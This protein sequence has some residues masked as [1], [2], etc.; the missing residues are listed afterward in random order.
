[1]FESELSELRSRLGVATWRVPV[2]PLIP[3]FS[4]LA[5]DL[6][7]L[8]GTILLREQLQPVF[9]SSVARAYLYA[10]TSLAAALR[11][12]VIV[13]QEGSAGAIEALLL[14]LLSTEL[15]PAVRAD[16]TSPAVGQV[17]VLE[18]GQGAMHF[19]RHNVTISVRDDRGFAH[20]VAPL[21]REID[22]ALKG[23]ATAAS[24]AGHPDAPRIVRFEPAASGVPTGGAVD[25]RVDVEDS[26]PPLSLL[27]SAEGGSYNVDPARPGRYYFR[28]GPDP[29]SG[30]VTLQAVNS[31]NLLARSRCEVQIS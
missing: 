11:L 28:A 13:D 9:G 5:T 29:G 4:P 3:G 24:L 30:V 19:I 25:L 1:M 23:R 10:D 14:H 6:P 12:T 26:H 18:E 20:L 15:A 8:S 21:A 22:D 17:H 31:L 2:P 27:F 16:P 7:S